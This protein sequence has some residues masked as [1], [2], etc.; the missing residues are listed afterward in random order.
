MLEGKHVT[1]GSY[2]R[3]LPSNGTDECY[4]A[5]SIGFQK[6]WRAMSRRFRGGLRRRGKGGSRCERKRR[7]QDDFLVV[8]KTRG[9]RIAVGCGAGV[10]RRRRRG[11]IDQV[12]V[13]NGLDRWPAAET[14]AFQRRGQCANTLHTD[15]ST[16]PPNPDVVI[17]SD[18]TNER[19]YAFFSRQRRDSRHWAKSDRYATTCQSET[20]KQKNG[21]DH[22]CSIL[23]EQDSSQGLGKWELPFP[24]S[25]ALVVHRARRNT[26]H[27]R[28]SARR[29]F[30]TFSR[31]SASNRL[32]TRRAV[33]ANYPNT[34]QGS[35]HGRIVGSCPFSPFRTFS[36]A[37][38]FVSVDAAQK[39]AYHTAKSR[40]SLC[41]MAHPTRVFLS[42]PFV[43]I[44]NG[45]L[46]VDGRRSVRG[47]SSFVCH[48][49]PFC[50]SLFHG[51]RS[52]GATTERRLRAQVFARC[53]NRR[54][55]CKIPRNSAAVRCGIPASVSVAVVEVVRFRRSHCR[56]GLK[57]LPS[58]L[59]RFRSSGQIGSAL[60]LSCRYLQP[61]FLLQWLTLFSAVL[62]QST[63]QARSPSSSRVVRP[64][65]RSSSSS[66]STR[67]PRPD[68]TLTR[69]SLVSKSTRSR[70]PSR[71]VPSGS[72]SAARSSLSSR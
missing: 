8:G 40:R 53:V 10:F 20:N 66:R 63:S 44:D 55:L 11:R 49:R 32:D 56:R 48:L 6:P 57:F 62:F 33:V 50:T 22:G 1:F 41:A 23:L 47:D 27:G 34:R 12:A 4:Q 65:R 30:A 7:R 13:G 54:R 19:P 14:L 68:L 24:K 46:G 60:L 29:R 16:S 18:G 39:A 28:K 21:C 25:G 70:S 3:W 5:G 17:G 35:C 52:R 67:A 59:L 43:G 64:A 61:N 31:L 72:P 51:T 58:V 42:K 45:A 38:V 9:K 26:V 69:S 71:W 15:T 36:I 37:S 2:R